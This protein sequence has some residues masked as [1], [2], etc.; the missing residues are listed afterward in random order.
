VSQ[1]FPKKNQKKSR[2]FKSARGS[3]KNLAEIWQKSAINLAQIWRILF[4]WS[5]PKCDARF[6][7]K[8]SSDL[9]QI[10]ARF[11]RFSVGHPKFESGVNLTKICQKSAENLT[12][13]V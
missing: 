7:A 11:W 6:D 1:I 4:G 5:G 2:G 3:S 9:R 10:F 13:S 8:F 12:P